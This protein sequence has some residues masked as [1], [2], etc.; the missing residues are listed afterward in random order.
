MKKGINLCI[1][2]VTI[3]C[4][5]LIILH[6]VEAYESIT[7]QEA[8]TMVAAGEAVMLDVRTL[9]ELFWVGSPSL[10]PGGD[11]IS[12]VIP[13]FLFSYDS[14]GNVKAVENTNFNQLVYKTFTYIDSP[15]ITICRS[16]NRS[17]LAAARLE[18]LG[19]TDVYIVDNALGENRGGVQGYNY[20]NIYEGY[21]GYPGRLPHNMNPHRI[22]VKTD[23]DR[24]RNPD[25]SVAWMD[26]GLPI[27][28]KRNPAMIPS[29]ESN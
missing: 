24:I 7:A 25:D 26:S 19:Y 8:F 6:K 10:V 9:E 11:P 2:V 17:S 18:S 12:Y 3:L 23:S 21:F 5:P 1:L 29:L 15:I 27:T 4:S 16:G 22:N 13:W 20:N 28:Q 14:N